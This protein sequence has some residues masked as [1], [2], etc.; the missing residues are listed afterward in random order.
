VAIGISGITVFIAISAT[1]PAHCFS[2]APDI[3]FA[4]C[5]FEEDDRSASNHA[6]GCYHLSHACDRA[7][8]YRFVDMWRRRCG[9]MTCGIVTSNSLWAKMRVLMAHRGALTTSRAVEEGIR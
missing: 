4:S 2:V 9:S 8:R 1:L 7:T 6:S 3:Q 5:L